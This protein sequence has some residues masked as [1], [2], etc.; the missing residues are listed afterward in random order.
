[1][2][3]E[4]I[5]TFFAVDAGGRP[6][7]E[8]HTLCDT[9]KTMPEV[10]LGGRR[11]AV[12]EQGY[13]LRFEDWDEEVARALAKKEGLKELAPDML[14]ALKFMRGYYSRY[15]FFPIIRAVCKNVHLPK[16]C[17]TQGF[18]DPAT[19]W[20]IAGLPNLGPEMDI[21]QYGPPD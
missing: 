17:I 11:I 4:R 10:E 5:F 1:M 16:D 3:C 13:L 14:D 7:F 8:T 21:F 12:D 2:A 15:H 18:I 20:K 19:A 6:R 9:I